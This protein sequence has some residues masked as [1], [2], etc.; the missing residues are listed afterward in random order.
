MAP[1]KVTS[2]TPSNIGEKNPALSSNT[3]STS[4]LIKDVV[5]TDPPVQK[6]KETFKIRFPDFYSRN[7]NNLKSF[8]IQVSLY[9]Y[10]NDN[11]FPSNNN[12]GL[13]VILYLKKE[14]LKWAKFYLK[15]Y[16]TNKN[17]NKIII[18]I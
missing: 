2:P 12:Y 5:I 7:K 4:P 18:T 1:K 11:K 14:A 6:L 8:L 16:L 17:I 9:A 15:N 13:W 10:L 3:Q